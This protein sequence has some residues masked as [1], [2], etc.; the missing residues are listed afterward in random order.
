MD[1]QYIY[2]SASSSSISPP[3]TNSS[4][5]YS[6]SGI[7]V[8]AK[9]LHFPANEAVSGAAAAAESVRPLSMSMASKPKEPSR[10]PSVS[11]RINRSKS[12]DTCAPSAGHRSTSTGATK[13]SQNAD[14]SRSK[15]AKAPITGSSSLKRVKKEPN[16]VP[17]VNP[18]TGPTT[19]TY[20][21]SS[22]TR[23][24]QRISQCEICAEKKQTCEMMR[25]NKKCVHSFCS[26]CIAKHVKTRVADNQVTVPCPGLDCE[27]K[28]EFEV[29]VGI[30]PKDVLDAWDKKLCEALILEDHKFYCPFSH[31][32]IEVHQYILLSPSSLVKPHETIPYDLGCNNGLDP[33]KSLFRESSRHNFPRKLKF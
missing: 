26:V 30:L 8:E 25:I 16:L 31:T 14:S 9:P 33:H 1:A 18:S 12:L 4:A 20:I 24:Y 19:I 6:R 2:S 29:C 22:Q 13:R 28:V 11:T 27:H 3:A 7:D 5:G 23:S 21:G 17:E 10:R 32:K 15:Q